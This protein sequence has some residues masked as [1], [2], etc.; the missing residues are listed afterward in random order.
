MLHSPGRTCSTGGRGFV[1]RSVDVIPRGCQTALRC[2]RSWDLT[3]GSTRMRGLA[4]KVVVVAGGG[5]GIGAATA[6]RLG[7]EGAAVVVGDL[8][9]RQR[10]RGRR[11]GARRRRSRD[12]GDVR[13]R[14]RGVGRRAA[15]AAAIAEYG[16]LDAMH[17]NAA[18]LSPETIG[19]DIECA[20]RP[21]R[22]VRRTRCDVNLHGPPAVHPPRAS[23]HLLE[24]GGGALVYTSSAAGTSASPSGRRTRRRRRASTRW[25]ATWRR[26]GVRNGI[27]ANSIAP[28]LVV[29][30]AMD[31]SLPS[32]FRDYAL[33]VGRS[34]RPRPARRHRRDGRVP[35]VRRRRV[36]QRPGAQRRRRRQHAPLTPLLRFG[37]AAPRIVAGCTRQMARGLAQEGV[38]GEAEEAF[39]DLAAHDLRRAAGDGEAAGEDLRL[40]HARVLPIGRVRRRDR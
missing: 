27:R 8:G 28:G 3:R 38:A 34:P 21:P 7:A 39:A 36:G 25:C 16:G 11:R 4:D 6:R 15:S 12:V 31:T 19:R 18:D 37:V 26:T 9:G 35:R 30:P 14:R 20:R 2:C 1:A 23:P 29:T 13:H 22:G 10:R 40:L 5:S 33:R 17:A 24:R 32:E